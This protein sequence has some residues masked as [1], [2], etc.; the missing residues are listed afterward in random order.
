[1][2]STKCLLR[3]YCKNIFIR[4]LSGRNAQNEKSSINK[5][6]ESLLVY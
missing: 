6:A 3:R 5:R 2:R 1:M 4:T